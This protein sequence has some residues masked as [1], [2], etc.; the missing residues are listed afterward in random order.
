M[1]KDKKSAKTSSATSFRE[2]L[3]ADPGTDLSKI[4][5]R[6]TP[7]F[8]GDKA[9]GQAALAELADV[10]SELQERLFAESK[11]G[12]GRSV[13]LVVQGMDTAGK[14]GIMRHVVGAVDPQGVDITSFK[15]PSAEERKHPFLW[16]IR[17]ALPEPG[18][19]GVFD[20][21]HYEDV[22]IVRV[23][24]LVPRAQWSR[25]YGQINTFEE[26]VADKG[27]T[28]IK[29]MLHI[30]KDEQKERLTERLDRPDKH[31]KFNPGD[32]DEREHWDD[33]Q[34]AYQAVIDKCSTE[35]APWYVVPADRKWFARLAVM[36]LLKE[37]LEELDPQWPK[38]DFDVAAEQKR[39]KKS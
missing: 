26:T 35:V 5:P 32:I 25:R 17:N 20:R 18:M 8:D 4:D 6:G 21:S 24:D 30:S 16:R 38:A 31:W 28:I 33:Y 13:L 9:A 10:L 15:A 14:G 23:H 19:I 7:G 34:E 2:V 22:L 11:A 37:H 36:Q 27:T 3:R 1:A 39:L 12:G 29:V